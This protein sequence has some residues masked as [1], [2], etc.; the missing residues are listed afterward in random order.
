MSASYTLAEPNFIFAVVKPLSW[1]YG[2][3]LLQG[4]TDNTNIII[5]HGTTPDVK[6]SDSSLYSGAGNL[7][8]GQFG[9]IRA[10][11]NG[12]N[13]S[14]QV[15][16]NAKINVSLTAKN[17]AGITL[18]ARRNLTSTTPNVVYAELIQA[19][20]VLSTTDET[21]IYNYLKTSYG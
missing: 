5:Q 18:A 16:E 11:F 17:P 3:Y 9:I 15:N 21:D 13:S 19:F 12:A 20:V 7:P 4:Y 6:I 1:T 10:L 8:I 2:D 14:L